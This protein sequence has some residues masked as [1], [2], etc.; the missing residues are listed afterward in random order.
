MLR[1]HRTS[2]WGLVQRHIRLLK[3]SA[4]VVASGRGEVSANNWLEPSEGSL[5]PTV[6]GSIKLLGCA[7]EICVCVLLGSV[8]RLEWWGIAG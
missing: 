6:A 7:L 4:Y 5:G 1:L 8:P 2:L 3:G